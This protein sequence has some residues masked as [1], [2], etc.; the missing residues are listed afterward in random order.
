MDKFILPKGKLCI[1]CGNSGVDDNGNPC[2]CQ[3]LVTDAYTSISCMEVPEQYRGVIFTKELLPLDVDE[4]YGIFMSNLYQSILG[5]SL[6]KENYLIASP[7]S[8]GK[9]IFAY[10]CIEQLFRRGYACMT[11][12][13]VLE[14]TNIMTNYDM[15]RKQTYDIEHPEYITTAPL[16]F[17]KI[18]RVARHDT[19]DSVAM[20][21]DR[22]VRHGCVTIFLYDGN[23][24]YL[25]SMDKNHIL[26][27]LS[28]NGHFNTVK[29]KTWS[30]TTPKMDIEPK[31]N[32]G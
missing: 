25:A 32:I 6:P 22:R 23:Y 15:G 8:H 17:A 14:L 2:D 27:G 24:S 9:S 12:Y 26:E 5:G 3:R 13:D 29:V 30:V 19:F 28:G 11:L 20:I 7:I 4:S 18:P 21:L 1:K 10:S 31:G 16:L